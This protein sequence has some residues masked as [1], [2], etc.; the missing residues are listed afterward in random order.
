M[1]SVGADGLTNEQWIR[2]SNPANRSTEA[3]GNKSLADKDK[4]QNRQDEIKS[5]HNLFPK[6]E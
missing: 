3:T 5:Q 1:E 4:S 2:D 6:G